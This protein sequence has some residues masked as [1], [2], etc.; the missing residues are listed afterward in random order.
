[1]RALAALLA[2]VAGGGCAHVHGR[3]PIAHAVARVDGGRLVPSSDAELDAAIRG[4]RVVYL[5][6]SHDDPH[7]HRFEEEL[8]A[9]AV[10]LDPATALGLEMLPRPMQP[11]L[12]DYVAG[13]TGERAFLRAVDWQHTW[14]FPFAFYRPL[15]SRCRDRH[16]RA[17]ALNAPA[18]LA[19]AIAHRGLAALTD[20]ERR[21]LPEMQPGPPAHRAQLERAFREHHG[22]AGAHAVSAESLERFYLA[23]LLWDETMAESIAR[24]LDGPA[25]P[26]RLVV[27]LGEGHA[28]R[29]AVPERAE[30]RGARPDVVIVSALRGQ[31]PEPGAAPDDELDGVDFVWVLGGAPWSAAP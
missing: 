23:Q 30:R 19:S 7:A 14:G 2:V 28:R 5:G 3:G 12:D 16:L 6:E 11:A 8:F 20:E 18:R 22:A 26:R 25:A 9:H 27:A 4:A 1:V 13:R 17:F 21:A 15:L 10:A 31:L 29:F 24:A